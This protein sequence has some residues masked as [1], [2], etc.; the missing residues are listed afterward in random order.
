MRTKIL[1]PLIFVLVFGCARAPLKE[2][3]QALRPCDKIEVQDSLPQDSLVLALKQNIQHLET[4]GT[5]MFQLGPYQVTRDQM[6]SAQK[7][8][9]QFVEANG[10]SKLSEGVQ[11]NFDFLEV[12]GQEKWGE[13]FVTSYFD[14]VIKG[15]P[16]P[17]KELTQPI[18]KLPSDLVTIQ[19]DQFLAKFPN[20][21]IAS[22]DEQRSSGSVLRGR[23]VPP[24]SKGEVSSVVPY[25]SREEI[26][27]GQTLK[28]QKL[29][30]VYVD[31]ID[32]FFLQIQGSGRIELPNKKELRVGYAG[33]N[34]YRYDAIGKF[35]KDKIPL[36]EMTMHTI[37][38]Y[39][40]SLPPEEAQKILNQNA[41]Y[42]FF[43]EN[44]AKSVTFLGSEVIPGRTIATD[45]RFFTK[46]VLAYLE[47]DTPVF[48]NGENLKPAKF[49]M[50]PRL[51]VDQ[52]T[53][54]A[55]RGGGRV[56]LYWGE[57]QEAKRSAGVMKQTGKLHYLIPKGIIKQ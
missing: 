27:V 3:A 57:G 5:P 45:H 33:Q 28:G 55:I 41:S 44:E 20:L 17:T 54:G 19:L 47:V 2:K 11:A 46:G 29:E 22:R 51:V 43:K 1:S 14:P 35:L 31:P 6:L 9:L 32:S 4:T 10:V 52:D 26:D 16:K 53:G 39:L 36:E 12:Y 34:G 56:D 7:N 15:S 18:Y 30:M 25:Y 42:V 50:K 24:R 23:L 8:L 37:E 40:R 49:E 21:A 48:E 38:A 13:V